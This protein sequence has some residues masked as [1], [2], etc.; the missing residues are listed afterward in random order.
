MLFAQVFL[1]RCLELGNIKSKDG[2]CKFQIRP[3]PRF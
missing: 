3:K 2:K 1:G